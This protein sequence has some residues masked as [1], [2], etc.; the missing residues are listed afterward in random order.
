MHYVITLLYGSTFW[1]A[2]LAL[3]AITETG[4][5]TL[6]LVAGPIIIGAAMIALMVIDAAIAKVW[7]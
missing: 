4:L 7:G 3:A 6:T 1:L 2:L 5:I